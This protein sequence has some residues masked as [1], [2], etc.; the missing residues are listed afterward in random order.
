MWKV[1]VLVS[2]I[3]LFQVLTLIYYSPDKGDLLRIGYII[4]EF[5]DYREKFSDN[6]KRPYKVLS[7]DQISKRE[8]Y[9]LLTIGDSFAEQ[10]NSGFQNC[11]A[12]EYGIKLVHIDRR[13]HTNQFQTLLELTNSDFFEQYKFQSVLIE[14]IE[15]GS[16]GVTKSLNFTS[17][18]S[19]E[20]YSK[21]TTDENANFTDR[22]V[23][24][25]DRI[26]KFPFY[27]VKRALY[28]RAECNQVYALPLKENPFSVPDSTLFFH[29]SNL[30][31]INNSDREDIKQLN[32]ILNQLAGRLEVKGVKLFVMPVPD[33]L[34]YYFELVQ[35]PDGLK[36]TEFFQIIQGLERNY[37]LI[38][39]LE[40]LKTN[41]GG[42][43][44]IFYYDDTH[45]S[46]IG[47][48]IIANRIASKISEMKREGINKNSDS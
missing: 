22:F 19:K 28:P 38:D 18:F 8:E 42:Q 17:S 10:G 48:R 29:A 40:V 43:K 13:L 37:E 12:V 9:H 46:P 35:D 7:V 47:A 16:H 21:R 14:F 34:D 33:K 31:T 2:P 4:D 1:F 6:Y 30:E 26:I 36:K 5:P 45:W 15:A 23:F 24:P 27:T 11:L 3:I 44:D 25:S 39:A 20:F 32:S 41:S